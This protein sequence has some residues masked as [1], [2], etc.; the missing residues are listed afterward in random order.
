MITNIR[1]LQGLQRQ[2]NLNVITILCIFAEKKK[3]KIDKNSYYLRCFDDSKRGESAYLIH[4]KKVWNNGHTCDSYT[5]D[6]DCIGF[7]DA[8]WNGINPERIILGTRILKRHFNRWA[9]RVSDCK[10]DIE[11]LVKS[12][13]EPFNKECQQGDYIY[14]DYKGLIA[15]DDAKEAE[16]YPEEYIADEHQY[17]GP[18]L[19]LVHLISKDTKVYNCSKIA[20]DEYFARI[21]ESAEFDLLDYSDYKHL[22][23]YIPKEAY[24]ES[25][26]IIR[27]TYNELMCEMKQIVKEIEKK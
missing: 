26:R 13:A 10:K 8:S 14:I 25:Q 17:D 7:E 6:P 2:N 1:A 27:E 23:F 12:S 20:I 9:K 22:L 15:E 3:M 4:Y 11:Q 24:E 18:D 16:E 21:K 5:I 19:L